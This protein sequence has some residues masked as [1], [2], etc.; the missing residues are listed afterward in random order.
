V[1]TAAALIHLAPGSVPGTD[2]RPWSGL[3]SVETET[4]RDSDRQFGAL[5]EVR[6]SACSCLAERPSRTARAQARRFVLRH[7]V[8]GDSVMSASLAWGA[9]VPVGS[10]IWG[11]STMTVVR[12]PDRFL[13]AMISDTKISYSPG[14]GGAMM[15][16]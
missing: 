4:R 13:P 6:Q 3:G 5:R 15:K 1:R 16:L 2:R 14:G 11:A 8:D 10:M 12:W 9:S 7:V